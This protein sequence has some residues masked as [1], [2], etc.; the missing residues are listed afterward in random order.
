VTDI[1]EAKSRTSVKF[2]GKTVKG[3]MWM[4]DRVGSSTI[5]YHF[6]DQGAMAFRKAAKVAGLVIASKSA[7]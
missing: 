3:M 1:I 4:R 6:P 7:H 2:T 5:T